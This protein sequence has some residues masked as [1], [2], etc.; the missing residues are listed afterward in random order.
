[1]KALLIT[2]QLINI[3]EGVCYS[4][5]A[6]LGTLNN[7]S[8]LGDIYIAACSEEPNKPAAQPIEKKI[9]FIRDNHVFFLRETSSSIKKYLKN[10][11]YNISL[12]KKIIPDMDLI[13][14]YVPNDTASMAFKIAKQYNKGILSFLVGCPWDTLHNHHRL[15]ARLMAPISYMSTKN[16]IKKSDYVH[17]VTKKFLQSRYPT[18]GLSLGC[19]DVNIKTQD[20]SVLN[21]R[22]NNLNSRNN[23]SNINLITI[24][25][26]DV[27]YKGHEYV[28]YAISK[29][30]KMGHNNYMYHLVGGGTGNY[31]KKL[32]KKLN[33]EKQV[34]FH[35]RKTA[36]EVI[37]CLKAAE[38]Y[39]QPSLTEGL[40]RS[41]IEAMSTALPCIGFNTGGIPELIE[42]KF[43]VSK[44][45]VNGLVNA[46]ISLENK[47]IYK[48]A[49]TRNYEESL[50]YDHL[51]LT[52]QIRTFFK[53]IAHKIS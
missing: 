34:I 39:I 23:S 27:R 51:I 26:V 22:I 20:I 14:L 43:I 36:D 35:G 3:R 37:D 7:M 19:S 15:L 13:I 32:C 50:K 49:A 38:I 4:N 47:Q 6:L 16:I 40:P 8:T 44:K 18:E 10:K 11:S 46:L 29:L 25:N 48:D 9:D 31:L 33:I 52:K 53:E 24:A 2:K 28:L 12:L 5:Y 42:S 45:D 41:I 21:N 1:M 17:Y 30:N